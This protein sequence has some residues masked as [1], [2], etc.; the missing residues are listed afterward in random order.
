[1]SKVAII[2][3][4]WNRITDTLACV[5]SLKHQTYKKYELFI[6]DNASS[7]KHT[8]HTLNAIA[9]RKIHIIYNDRNL[10]FAGGV[11]SGIQHALAGD[12]S[13]V[14]L[15]NNDA[16]AHPAWLAELITASHTHHSGITTS[17]VLHSNHETIDSTGDWYSLWGLP[18]PR[19][20]DKPAP[21]ASKSG[22]VFGGSGAGTLYDI[23]IFRE[24]GMFDE[25]FFMYYE[26]VDLSFRAQLYGHTAYFTDKAIIY[27]KRGASSTDIPALPIYHTFKNLPLLYIK[28]VPTRLL[29]SVTI[30]FALAYILIFGNALRKRHALA[31]VKGLFVGAYL[32]WRHA[33]PARLAIQRGRTVSDDYTRSIIWADLPPDQTGLRKL[34][35]FFTGK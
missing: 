20:R 25:T 28:N 23:A 24:V 8:K 16:T 6:V 32:F 34:R 5:D 3:L 13:H 19:D 7:E 1:M 21:Q 14:A 2:I 17:L 31:A 12:F 9:S 4:N 26:D 18:F 30:R 11:N 33:F 27:H 15:I 10:G 35:R 22:F 29:P